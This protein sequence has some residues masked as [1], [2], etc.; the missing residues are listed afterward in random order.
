MAAQ[1]QWWQ[2]IGN[3]AQIASAV[4]ALFGFAVIIFQVNELRS[5]NRASGARQVYLAYS[6]LSFRYPQFSA[7]D[8]AAL[9]A[10]DR[11]VFEQYKLFVSYLLYACGAVLP[12][13][14]KEP[15]W[16]KSCEYEVKN[17]LPFL[18]EVQTS[19]PA[20]LETFGKDTIGFVRAEMAR[21]GVAAPDCKLRKS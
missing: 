21:A 10:G 14:A 12:A 9:K 8:Y 7:P 6:D 19:D 3:A 1:A 17:H 16:R 2:R 15:E 13:F 5:N 18:C 4:I 11:L 20:F